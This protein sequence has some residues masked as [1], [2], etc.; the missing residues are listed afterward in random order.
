MY[1]ALT[2]ASPLSC[3]GS[4]LPNASLL[5]HPLPTQPQLTAS[6]FL[7]GQD[8]MLDIPFANLGW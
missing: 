1:I 8:Y 3:S 7:R 5:R 6:S 4:C 2:S